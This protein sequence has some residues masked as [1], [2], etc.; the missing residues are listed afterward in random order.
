[1]RS[2][3]VEAIQVGAGPVGLARGEAGAVWAV[4]ARGDAV[5]RVPAGATEPDLVVEVPGT[6]LRATWAHDALWVTSFGA[7]QLVRVDPVSGT[8]TDRVPT[9]AGPEGVTAAFGSLWVVAQ[10]AGRLLRIDPRTVTVTHRIEIGVGARL[11]T[12]GPR[13]LYVSHYADGQVLRIDPGT[14][15]LWRSP[16]V[17]RGPQGMALE[18]GR[19]WVAC[20]AGNRLLVLDAETLHVIARLPGP[21]A[22]DPV[23]VAPDGTVLAVS[24]AGPT[25]VTVDPVTREPV[26]RVA[27]GEADQLFDQANLDALV[28]GGQ[29]WVTS[30]N[31]DAVL[32]VPL[33]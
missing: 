3:T 25:V 32:R 24:Q 30:F 27:L 2:S 13:W 7:E 16:E 22:P 23:T 5:S 6:P 14:G 17:C 28:S 21:E 18:Q 4:S 19:L 20:T 9:G 31:D 15:H 11:V 8:I 26:S 12:A 29:V 10:D 33:P 1:M